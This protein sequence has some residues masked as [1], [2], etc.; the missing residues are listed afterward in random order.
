MRKSRENRRQG[1]TKTQEK[2]SRR[3]GRRDEME[4]TMDRPALSRRR[5]DRRITKRVAIL[6]VTLLIPTATNTHVIET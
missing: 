5:D 1:Q 4:D 2:G 6:K 3:Q